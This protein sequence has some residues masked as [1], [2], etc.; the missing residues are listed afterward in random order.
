M[1]TNPTFDP[2]A[3]IQSWHGDCRQL[4][5]LIPDGVVDAVVTDPPYGIGYIHAG[6]GA[7]PAGRWGAGRRFATPIMGDD[8]PFDPAPLLR[9]GNVLTWGA[10]HY[11]A[12]LPEGGRWLAWSK[13][14]DSAV[15]DSFG[16]VDFAWHSRPGASRIISCLWKGVASEKR[17]ESNGR[18]WHPSQKPVRVMLW[19][20]QQTGVPPGGLILDPYADSGSTAVA[21]LRAG[22]R[23]L[24]IESDAQYLPIIERRVSEARTPLFDLH[25]GT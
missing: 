17:G 1:T 12:R 18:R 3:D 2:T 23:C 24:L 25:G 8:E 10:N 6:G 5:A 19:S 20:I 4:M 15:R 7:K 13:V 11:A 9:F 22:Y 14:A 21:C 16:D